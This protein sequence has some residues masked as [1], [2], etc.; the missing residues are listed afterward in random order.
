[1]AADLVLLA[2]S[3]RQSLLIV[4]SDFQGEHSLIRLLMTLPTLLFT[5]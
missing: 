3:S 1:M 5:A 2:K 4:Q